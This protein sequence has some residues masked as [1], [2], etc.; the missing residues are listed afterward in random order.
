VIVYR[1]PFPFSRVKTLRFLAAIFYMPVILFRDKID[2]I[3]VNGFLESIFIPL[4]RAC[5]K[6]AI[7]TRHGPSE[8]ELYKWYREPLRFFPRYI[9]RRCLGLSSLIVCVS[10]A[11]GESQRGFLPDDRIEIISNWVPDYTPI[12]LSAIN[13]GRAAQVLYVGRL[14]QYKGLYILLEALK[15]IP[16]VQLVVIGEGAYRGQLEILADG[17]NARFEGFQRDVTKYYEAADVFVMPSLGP[18]GLPMVTLEAM[19]R[20]LPCIF[21]DL[22]V[23]REVAG[24]PEAAMLFHTGDA[25]D[26]R[27]KLI[28]MISDDSLRL[29]YARKAFAR[30]K[31]RYSAHA[32]L[33]G[34]FRV[35][36]ISPRP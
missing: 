28:A 1:I 6:R 17:I 14:E 29:G 4:A 36:G 35:F 7:Y 16:G 12:S 23:H 21:S 32:A 9:S 26:L 3:Q 24:S 15:D 34:Y 2:T 11:V 13:N 25:I 31:N 5:R 8:L 27:D 30:V 22:P 10:E 20:G 18:E 33:Q 19:G